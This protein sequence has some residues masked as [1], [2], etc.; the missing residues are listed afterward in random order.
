MA[1][2]QTATSQSSLT[3]VGEWV[4]WTP[5]EA[6][7]SPDL[8]A[9][10]SRFDAVDTA[11]GE[12]AAAF[13]RDRALDNDGSTK[14]YLLVVEGEVEGFFSCCNGSVHLSQRQSRK[15]RVPHRKTLPAFVVAWIARR[16]GGSLGGAHL[17]LKA[18]SV[19]RQQR[20]HVGCVVLALDPGDPAVARLWRERYEFEP[21]EPDDDHEEGLERLWLRID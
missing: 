20:A 12:D 19:A 5:E 6:E 8:C 2:P 15:L 21:C 9:A 4:K 18:I 10:V 3:P 16:R 1:P 17:V 7:R 11:M 14:T 13:L